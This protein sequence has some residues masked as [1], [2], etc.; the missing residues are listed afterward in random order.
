MEWKVITEYPNAELEKKWFE[1]LQDSTHSSHYTSPGFHKMPYWKG[2][3][4]FT[5]LVLD[6]GKIVGV[7]CSL[8]EEKEIMAGLAVRPQVAFAKDADASKVAETMLEGLMS[9]IG[10]DG[11]LI[12]LHSMA[13]I[14]AFEELG[15]SV[16]RAEGSM[17]LI[18]LDLSEGSEDIFKNFSQSRRSDIRK[19]LRQGKLE[20]KEL[21]TFEE[22]KE[23]HAIHLDWCRF[24]EVEPETF[25]EFKTAW[26]QKDYLRIFIAK[27]EGKVI[28]G[29][30]FRFCEG[31]LVEYS[32]NNSMPE[33][34]NLRPNDVIVWKAIEWSA[35]QGFPYFSMGGS[36]LFLRRFGGNVW[37]SY[38]YQL[39]RTLFKK[40]LAKGAISDIA[41]KTYQ[42][43]APSTRQKIKKVLGR[44]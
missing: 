38:R 16:K 36:H 24:K 29:S 35:E 4:P 15:L 32:A 44:Q 41:I 22:I 2:K 39:D 6:D 37:R 13:K 18:V 3:N 8:H 31:G 27:T 43:L 5:V 10:K 12:T 33:Y 26:Q 42:S 9:V 7:A 14:E 20:I 1:F 40:H 28:A 30:I 19:A 34:R 23:L 17:E 21:E 25:E 11:E